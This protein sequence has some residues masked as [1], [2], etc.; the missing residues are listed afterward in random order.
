MT[1]ETFYAMAILLSLLNAFVLCLT[2]YKFFHTYQLNNYH[3]ERFMNWFKNTNGKYFSRLAVMSIISTA[4]LLVV[5]VL[6]GEYL[7]GVFAFVGLI[8]YFVVFIIFITHENR[9][10]KKKP[11]AFTTRVIRLYCTLGIIAFFF[12]IGLFSLTYYLAT[13]SEFFKVLG[14]S[15]ISLS[16]IVLPFLTVFAALIMLPYERLRYVH[17]KKKSYKVLS[18]RKDLIKIGITGSYGKT[19]VKNFLAQILS[20]KYDVL[21][22]PASYN[23]PMGISKAITKLKPEHQIF[24]AE[25]GARNVGNIRELC[26]L[27]EPQY[28]IITGIGNQHLETF[29]LIDNIKREKFELIKCLPKDGF[30]VVSSDSEGSAEMAKRGDV[31]C[32]V[33]ISGLSGDN[34]YA[35]A[36]NLIC[37][38]DGSTFTLKIDGK[39]IACS[40]VLLGRHSI[41]NITAA[42][43]LAYKLGVTL[44]DISDAISEIKPVIHRLELIV[45]PNNITVIDDTFNASVEGTQA[46]LETLAMF[47]GRKIVITPG[48]VELGVKEREINKD[49]GVR[50]AKICDRVFLIGEMRSAPIHEGLVEAGFPET[51]ISVYNSLK[52][53]KSVLKKELKVGDIV[54]WE[55][56]LPDDYN[57]N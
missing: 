30:A 6:F 29:R 52:E 4:V 28:A 26:E 5:N 33:V 35:N 22:T 24:I 38:K 18:E 50:M 55:N 36:S 34:A 57:E 46:A 45:N 25:M 53:V 15:T 2:A 14:F 17:Y 40:T 31:P 7:D 1:S 41:S 39:E 56:D 11:L 47:E 13:V 44:E 8:F 12:S 9:I 23:T 48:L 16:P 20:K 19:S 54:L 10:P 21:P 3:L 49:F 42:A 43:A 37:G 51:C 32:P 27:V